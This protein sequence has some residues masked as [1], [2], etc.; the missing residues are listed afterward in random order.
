MSHITP[1]GRPLVATVS[2]RRFPG[3]FPTEAA[4]PAVAGQ[5]GGHGA[6]DAPVR[7]VHADTAPNLAS[8]A[9]HALLC[10]RSSA[11]LWAGVIREHI[12]S[13]F[14]LGS[15]S[16]QR[17]PWP[18]VRDRLNM[19]LRGWSNHFRHGVR[20]ELP[21]GGSFLVRNRLLKTPSKALLL[22]AVKSAN[23]LRLD[24][25]TLF[26]VQNRNRL[27]ACPTVWNIERDPLQLSI[28][29]LGRIRRNFSLRVC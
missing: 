15:N 27:T 5:C 12:R 10:P 17:A 8:S 19:N 1:D 14:V 29:S 18:E 24:S 16:P 26:L 7:P 13:I 28:A 11:G 4:T 21:F 6:F 22:T 23:G 3:P 25:E 20:S 9:R 2:G